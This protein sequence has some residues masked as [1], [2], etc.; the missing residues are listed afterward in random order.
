MEDP[1]DAQFGAQ[2]EGKL[3]RATCEAP[4]DWPIVRRAGLVIGLVAALALGTINPALAHKDHKKQAEAA[5]ATPSQPGVAA[6]M[7]DDPT[8]MHASSLPIPAAIVVQG[9][10]GGAM[11]H[12][13]DHMKW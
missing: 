12:G 1:V 9:W 5:Q 6:A 13:V 2:T 11:V 8:A 4:L 3:M 10:Y 7:R